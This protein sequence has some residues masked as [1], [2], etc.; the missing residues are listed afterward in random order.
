[1]VAT[2]ESGRLFD[3]LFCPAMAVSNMLFTFNGGFIMLSGYIRVTAST[4]RMT[5]AEMFA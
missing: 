2:N 3:D 1:M 5:T 4:S